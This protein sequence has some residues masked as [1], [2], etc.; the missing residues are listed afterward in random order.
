MNQKIYTVPEK[1]AA[2]AR[3]QRGDNERM[4]AESIASPSGPMS[5]SASTGS[6][7][8][9]S[10]RTPAISRMIFTSAGSAMAH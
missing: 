4:Y 8:P 6:E 2:E 3:I 7:Y 9:R 5:H 1:F 10:S